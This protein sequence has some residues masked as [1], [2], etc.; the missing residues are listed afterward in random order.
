MRD[1]HYKPK[2]LR[3]DDKIWEKLKSK[4]KKSG[5][6]YNMFIKKLLEIYEETL[7]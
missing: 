1:K 3:L 4:Q 6:S 2:S 7:H 5:L